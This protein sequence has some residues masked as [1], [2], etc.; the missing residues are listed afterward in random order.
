MPKKKQYENAL[1]SVFDF[2]FTESQK[3]PDKRKPLK[4]TGADGTT[5]FVNAIAAV[6]EQ[7]GQFVNNT[8]IDAFNDLVNPEIA[9]VEL[10]PTEKV[11]FSLLNV[12]GTL[13]ND[14]SFVD[15][16]FKRL[17]DNRKLGKLAWGG[18]ALSALVA[19]SWAKKYGLDFSTQNALFNMGGGEA[20]LQKN[21]KKEEAQ[22]GAWA[23][24]R[25]YLQ[26]IVTGQFG[27]YG[28]MSKSDFQSLYGN[29]R[30]GQIYNAIQE[31]FTAYNDG[32]GNAQLSKELGKTF[33]DLSTKYYSLLYPIFEIDSMKMR[34]AQARASGDEEL[35]NRYQAAQRG[36][37]LFSQ[38]DLRT[39]YMMRR[40]AELAQHRRNLT[41]MRKSR[42]PNQ[43]NMKIIQGHIKNISKE[44]RMFKLQGRATTLGEWDAM[45]TSVK[46]MWEYTA[47][48]QFVPAILTGDFYDSRKNTMFGKS[49]V[50]TIE[51]KLIGLDRYLGSKAKVPEFKVARTDGNKYMNRY[52]ARMT[53]L[54]Y[55]TPASWIKTLYT[56]EGFAHRAFKQQERFL[57]M[58]KKEGW[59]YIVDFKK[60]FGKDGSAYLNS[61]SGNLTQEQLD[62]LIRFVKKNERLQKLVYRFGTLGRVNARITKFLTE[63]FLVPTQ[64]FRTR[65][66]KLLLKVIKDGPAIKLIKRW[67]RT[68]GFRI[69]VM[70]IKASVK[71]ALGAGTGGLSF[72]VDFLVDWAV[73]L[74]MTITTKIA[75]PIIK[76]GNT[77]I[78]LFVLTIVGLILSVLA[79]ATPSRYAHVAPHE[80]VLGQTDFKVPIG[81][82]GP[83]SGLGAPFDGEPLPPGVECVLGTA[84]Y[85]P[86]TQAPGPERTQCSHKNI[87]NAIDVG[88]LGF[89]YAPS[90]CGNGNCRILE[91]GLYP[92]CNFDGGGQ[93]IFE[94]EYEGNVYKFK[95]VHV[96]MDPSLQVGDELSA[97][98]VVARI[99]EVDVDYGRTCSTGHHL[100]LEMWYNGEFVNPET[101]LRESPANGGFGCPLGACPDECYP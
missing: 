95:L 59:Q 49:L 70:G 16:Q 29:A 30:G 74:V 93:V 94:A 54:Y 14:M 33:D 28:N 31:T 55:M 48:G 78:V 76:L 83:G 21:I 8:T 40:Q 91:N 96:E 63:R 80:I 64:R 7:P 57:A 73:N 43:A 23:K 61:L 42:N 79:L 99:M 9:T 53:D 82:G 92:Y 72:V 98:Q 19:T 75:I 71:A 89:F 41:A 50:P 36:I 47:G 37:D 51:T 81:G 13:E 11:K 45:L 97:G 15:K 4:V 10:S 32:I 26:R 3:A 84:S 52:Y 5:E 27:N 77:L 46:N 2:V 101:I 85:Y 65:L 35:A 87:P 90:F 67:M 12:K 25:D 58:M 88:Y 60:L 22:L 20:F 44:L 38:R 100:H 1:D 86:C 34:E 18:Q 6:L 66:G 56:G 62:K 68:G 69:L 24:N 39:R 17:E